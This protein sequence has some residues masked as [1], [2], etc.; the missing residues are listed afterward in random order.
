MKKIKIRGKY[1]KREYRF[2][3]IATRRTQEIIKKIQLLGNCSNKAFYNYDQW[4]VEKI[5]ETIS[6]ELRMAHARFVYAKRKKEFKL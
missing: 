1:E 4:Q 2:E 6:K 5:F 3:R